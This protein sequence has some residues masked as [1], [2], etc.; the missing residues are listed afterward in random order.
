M[1]IPIL[2]AALA[3]AVAAVAHAQTSE[4]RVITDEAIGRA[5]SS[6]PAPPPPPA[7]PVA[8]LPSPT[9]APPAVVQTRLVATM[10]VRA[11]AGH[12]QRA[13]FTAEV[14][15]EGGTTYVLGGVG[16]TPFQAFLANCQPSG[17]ACTDIELYAGF[18]GT[19]RIAIERINA[20]NDR[21]RFTR[22]F[23]D[24]SR[25]PALQMDVT[26]QG[27]I[28]PDALKSQLE[29]WGKALETYSLFLL[30][31]VPPAGAVA[32]PGPAKR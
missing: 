4:P 30:A 31:R 14:K 16:R 27:G 23:L 17:A 2:A 18:S 29:I 26:L 7:A 8:T 3:V 32:P 1:R 24:E 13:G 25:N 10:D 22:A 9:V 20:W 5:P 15:T 19:Q 21:T 11:L 28:S 6:R 12:L